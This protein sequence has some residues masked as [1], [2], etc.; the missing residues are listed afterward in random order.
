M[1]PPSP[2]PPRPSP[3]SP[4]QPVLFLL[5]S[6]FFCILHPRFPPRPSSIRACRNVGGLTIF[7][8]IRTAHLGLS[9]RSK[10]C[11]TMDSFTDDI[12]HWIIL[13]EGDS[14]QHTTE[15]EWSRPKQGMATRTLLRHVFHADVLSTLAVE[16]FSH[17]GSATPP[18]PLGQSKSLSFD[19]ALRPTHAAEYSAPLISE[20]R[21]TDTHFW[22]HGVPVMAAHQSPSFGPGI[23]DLWQP[24]SSCPCVSLSMGHTCV[25]QLRST[26]AWVSSSR[27]ITLASHGSRFALF[28]TK[29]RLR[30]GIV[31]SMMVMTFN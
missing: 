26:V 13:P 18:F 3:A 8:G 7:I 28:R 22:P 16:L 14:G 20:L 11:T 17:T 19:A 24:T 2:Y 15:V 25:H 6:P 27:T 5:H 4:T 9:L 30:P 23:D 1:A 12:G 10:T 21:P 31:E 29:Q